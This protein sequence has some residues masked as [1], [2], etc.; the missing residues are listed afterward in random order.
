M[1]SRTPVAKATGVSSYVREY[2]V[3]LKMHKTC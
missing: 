1:M 2:P 3:E